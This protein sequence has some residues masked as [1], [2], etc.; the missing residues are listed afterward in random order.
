VEATAHKIKK[1]EGGYEI[2]LGSQRQVPICAAASVA[3]FIIADLT[4]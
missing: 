1:A 2:E 4:R 3:F